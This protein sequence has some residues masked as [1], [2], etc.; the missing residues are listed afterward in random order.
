MIFDMSKHSRTK[1]VP[2]IISSSEKEILETAEESGIEEQ[3]KGFLNYEL[4]NKTGCSRI[5]TIR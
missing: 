2:L 5:K 3:G 1:L 4:N